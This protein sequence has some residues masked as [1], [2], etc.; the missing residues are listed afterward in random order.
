MTGM[1]R[2]ASDIFDAAVAQRLARRALARDAVKPAGPLSGQVTEISVPVE[3]LSDIDEVLAGVARIAGVRRENGDSGAAP[4]ARNHVCYT[5]TRVHYGWELGGPHGREFIRE[6][7]GLPYLALL[8]ERA[9]QWIS[10][11]ELLGASHGLGASATKLEQLD[12]AGEADLSIIDDEAVKQ[13]RAEIRRLQVEE[14]ELRRSGDIDGALNFRS[15]RE[16]VEHYL[17]AAI[18]VRGRG[19]KTPRSDRL[20]HAVTSAIRR[21]LGDIAEVAPE[22]AAS[23]QR[24]LRT[25]HSCCFDPAGG[26]RWAVSSR[27]PTSRM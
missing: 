1:D 26:E 3:L 14:E 5:L 22:T 25:G 8:V 12:A 6:S 10:C 21:S 13:Y 23:I 17:L 7:T 9:G 11:Q 19:R 20:R 4:T 2:S 15:Q 24:S 18:D 27:L 16:Q